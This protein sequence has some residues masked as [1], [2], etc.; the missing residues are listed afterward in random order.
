MLGET[1]R[2]Q[3]RPHRLV[4][5]G[6]DDGMHAVDA[7]AVGKPYDAKAFLAGVDAGDVRRVKLHVALNGST[8]ADPGEDEYGQERVAS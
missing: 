7:R 6:V 8:R 3:E 1:L 5:R 4:A 2:R